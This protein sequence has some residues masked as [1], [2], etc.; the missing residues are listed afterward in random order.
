MRKQHILISAD[1]HQGQ[2]SAISGINSPSILQGNQNRNTANI[3]VPCQGLGFTSWEN[4]EETSTS[5][6]QPALSSTNSNTISAMQGQE[7]TIVG[8]T[9]NLGNKQKLMNCVYPFEEWQ[10]NSDQSY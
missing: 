5:T 8:F 10:V 7:D 6:Y 1:D 3:Y 4:I 2:F 9:N